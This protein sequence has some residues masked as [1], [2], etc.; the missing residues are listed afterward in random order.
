MIAMANAGHFDEPTGKLMSEFS[1]A[2][3]YSGRVKPF[4]AFARNG[5][6][7][8]RF[9]SDALVQTIREMLMS[10]NGTTRSNAAIAYDHMST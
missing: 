1:D 6:G 8:G 10:T 3:F 7:L 2:M 4:K 5:E 9:E